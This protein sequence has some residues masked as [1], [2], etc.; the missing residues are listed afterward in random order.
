MINKTIS[1]PPLSDD[2][3]RDA[4]AEALVR[5][6]SC[7]SQQR[8]VASVEEA[9]E[10][11]RCGVS[12]CWCD[13]LGE[14]D[15]SSIIP[16]PRPTTVLLFLGRLIRWNVFPDLPH[17]HLTILQNP[18]PSF[19]TTQTL[20]SLL[21]TYTRPPAEAVENQLG[22][23]SV[24]VCSFLYN[25][26]DGLHLLR[27]RGTDCLSSRHR[28]LLFRLPSLILQDTFQLLSSY[29]RVEQLLVFLGTIMIVK[30]KWVQESLTPVALRTAPI[31][32]RST[33]NE[34]QETF[35]FNTIH[36]LG[37]TWPWEKRMVWSVGVIAV[38]YIH[39]S[40]PPPPPPVM[41]ARSELCVRMEPLQQPGWPLFW[42]AN[43][44]GSAHDSL[45]SY[46]GL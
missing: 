24:C 44:L 45:S 14:T 8:E 6:T 42:L 2:L 16:P 7:H 4:E 37:G 22:T 20:A 17:H 15:D 34:A 33:E 21:F 38:V 11:T 13:M 3:L 29:P 41:D 1:L 31:G 30:R 23:H 36:L 39:D 26:W 43:D 10:L 40:V 32:H 46:C 9:V 5:P 25:M 12:A 18:F 27:L 35:I 28:P 19:Y